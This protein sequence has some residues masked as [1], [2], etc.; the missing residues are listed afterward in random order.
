MHKGSCLCGKITFVVQGDLK[1]LHTC[2][3]INCRKGSGHIGAGTDI[4]REALTIKD[5]ENIT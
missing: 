5:E 2:H 1:P 3:C 4:D